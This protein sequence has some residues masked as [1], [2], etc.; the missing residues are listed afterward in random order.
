MTHE[1]KGGSDT[2]GKFYQ[3]FLPKVP[4][5][6]GT[7]VSAYWVKMYEKAIAFYKDQNKPKDADL[8]ERQL[9]AVRGGK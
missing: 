6:R 8:L 7:E 1:Y 3:E 2:L 4:P 9:S 5:R